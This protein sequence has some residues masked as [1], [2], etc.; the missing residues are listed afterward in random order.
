M[1]LFSRRVRVTLIDD[2]SGSIIG[3]TK[4]TADALPAAF[5]AST[6]LHLGEQDWSVVSADPITRA[7]YDNSR[8]LTLRLRPI[9]CSQVTELLYSLP[10]IC[11][12]LPM[13]DGAEADGTEIVLREDDWRQLELVSEKWRGSVE[14]EIAA[15]RAIREEQRVGPGF[16]RLHVRHSVPSPLTAGQVPLRDVQALVGG[17]LQRPLRFDGLGT[18][19]SSGFAFSFATSEVLYGVTAGSDVQML[20]FC[21]SASIELDG[22]RAFA[23]NLEVLAVDWCRCLVADPNDDAF[24]SVVRGAAAG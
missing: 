4:M 17:R 13:S 8:R 12:G 24:E 11:D 19:V 20:G 10:T 18:R 9:E 21:P 7:E 14:E 5:F 2:R 23:D 1:G 22:L 15:I 16:R 6:T 3:V